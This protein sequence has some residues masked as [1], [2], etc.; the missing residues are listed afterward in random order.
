VRIFSP[1][2]SSEQK[3]WEQGVQKA[4]LAGSPCQERSALRRVLALLSSWVQEDDVNRSASF[5][6]AME[7]PLLCLVDLRCGTLNDDDYL[8]TKQATK[9]TNR[10]PPMPPTMR[11]TKS[12]STATAPRS[13][14]RLAR[15]EP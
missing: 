7:E 5:I 14:V 4:R 6:G 9:S 10:E 15:G 13:R 2:L 12:V 3:H 8:L 11:I 1:P